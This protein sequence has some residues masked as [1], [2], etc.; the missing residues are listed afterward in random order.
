MI[1]T[2]LFNIIEDYIAQPDGRT[3]T[4]T[5]NGYVVVFIVAIVLAVAGM[6]M[7][8][9]NGIGKTFENNQPDSSVQATSLKDQG[10]QQA[11]DAEEQ[12]RAYMEDIKQKMRDS[13]RR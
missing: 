3:Y 5:M 8:Y 9:L 4:L 10:K 6:S 2:C 11:K 13:Q 12:R 1:E 7:G